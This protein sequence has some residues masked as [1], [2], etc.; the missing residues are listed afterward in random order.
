MSVCEQHSPEEL[1]PLTTEQLAEEQE[2][3][4]HMEPPAASE[5]QP[6]TSGGEQ[7]E[8]ANGLRSILTEP[9]LS[10]QPARVSHWLSAVWVGGGG[11][12]LSCICMWVYACG[13]ETGSQKNSVSHMCV[14]I[15]K[16]R[17]VA[18]NVVMRWLHIKQNPLAV[19]LVA[20]K[21]HLLTVGLY[22]SISFL[23]HCT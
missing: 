18:Q 6:V 16:V 8:S 5:G 10:W 3:A 19:A 7:P 22:Y 12:K 1:L 17:S 20:L 9:N 4:S 23:P 13:C 14:L 2:E 11:C 21:Q 15:G